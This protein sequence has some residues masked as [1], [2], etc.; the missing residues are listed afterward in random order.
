M[1]DSRKL[2]RYKIINISCTWCRYFRENGVTKAFTWSGNGICLVTNLHHFKTMPIHSCVG[3]SRSFNGISFWDTC[4]MESNFT[5][6]K[7]LAINL[8]HMEICVRTG[9]LELLAFPIKTVMLVEV[10]RVNVWVVIFN[11]AN[12]SVCWLTYFGLPSKFYYCAILHDLLEKMKQIWFLTIVPSL[13]T[14]EFRIKY[15]LLVYSCDDDDGKIC[16]HKNI[17][18]IAIPGIWKP[19]CTYIDSQRLKN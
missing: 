10:T 12:I 19:A 11:S 13:K 16:F 15:H 5:S 8:H 6:T 3:V 14:S 4:L 17:T 9:D 18:N 2:W 7:I 1:P